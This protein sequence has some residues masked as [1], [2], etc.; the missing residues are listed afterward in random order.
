MAKI[1][2]WASSQTVVASIIA[3]VGAGISFALDP[4]FYVQAGQC[5]EIM[6]K[7][8]IASAVRS[9]GET[10]AILAPIVAVMGRIR[11]GGVY[12]PGWLPGPNRAELAAQRLNEELGQ[13]DA[14]DV[15]QKLEAIQQ[16]LDGE[17]LL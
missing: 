12:T 8:Q 10:V 9:V 16:T 1:K 6:G 2:S 17:R 13:R 14:N 5:A 7:D 3:A 11:A 4:R 15:Y